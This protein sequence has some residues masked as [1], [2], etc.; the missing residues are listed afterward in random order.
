[1]KHLKSIMF[2]MI[3]P[4]T[5]F[6][7]GIGK[8]IDKYPLNKEEKKRSHERLLKREQIIRQQMEENPRNKAIIES[9][10]DVSSHGK[11]NKKTKDQKASQ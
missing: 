7:N 5:S 11:V 1:M 9:F 6:S 2:L 3:F 10:E 8:N 4:L